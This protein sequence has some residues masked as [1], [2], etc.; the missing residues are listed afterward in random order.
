MAKLEAV[1]AAKRVGYIAVKR[2]V[3]I[4]PKLIQD[5]Q[6]AGLKAHQEEIKLHAALGS[7]L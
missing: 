3:K 6:R 7:P 4:G 2:L 5:Y 1:A